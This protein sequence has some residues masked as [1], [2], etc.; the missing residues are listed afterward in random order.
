MCHKLSSVPF[1]WKGAPVLSLALA[2]ATQA[3]LSARA[4]AEYR[5]ADAEMTRVY[6]SLQRTPV[7]IA[8]QRA[9]ILYRDAHCLWDHDAT[10][11]GSMY[12]MEEAMCKTRL[13]RERTKILQRE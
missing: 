11:D 3:D 12:G 5:A 1:S 8:A 7:L 2:L 6:R 9:W 4:L 13:T 10:P